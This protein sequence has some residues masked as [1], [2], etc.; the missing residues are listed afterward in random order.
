MWST[1]FE[2]GMWDLIVPDHCLS[3]YLSSFVITPTKLKFT[4]IPICFTYLHIKGQMALL[5]FGVPFE[6]LNF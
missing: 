1:G 5:Y 4:C 6:S 3:I 2:G